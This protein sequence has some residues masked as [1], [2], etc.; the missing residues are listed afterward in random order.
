MGNRQQRMGSVRHTE[1]LRETS[2]MSG[3]VPPDR[4]WGRNLRRLRALMVWDRPYRP[5]GGPPL[6]GA[7]LRLWGQ[8]DCRPDQCA[9]V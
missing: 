7:D 5:M 3:Y 6:E 1:S 4:V 8:P 2:Y 9:V